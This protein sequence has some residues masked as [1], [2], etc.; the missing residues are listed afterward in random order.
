MLKLSVKLFNFSEME[1]D[2]AVF[3]IGQLMIENRRQKPNQVTII[4]LEGPFFGN[5]LKYLERLKLIARLFALHKLNSVF[6]E[7]C[8]LIHSLSLFVLFKVNC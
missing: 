8:F 5:N 7:T 2:L 6:F 3:F 4:R 1:L